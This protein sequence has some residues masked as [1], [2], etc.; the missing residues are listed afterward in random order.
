MKRVEKWFQKQD[1]Y[2]I[3]FFLCVLIAFFTGVFENKMSAGV[4]SVFI[5]PFLIYLL[6]NAVEKKLLNRGADIDTYFITNPKQ[7]DIIW[8]DLAI[9]EMD[10]NSYLVIENTG[11]VDMY[12]FYIKIKNIDGGVF[13]CKIE[14][15]LLTNKKCIVKIPCGCREISEIVI[16]GD[17]LTENK[18]KRFYGKQSSNGEKTIFSSVENCEKEKDSITHEHGI[19]DFVRLERVYEQER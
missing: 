12:E 18:T 16:S 13:L 3:L 15:H 2:E 11:H 4:Y 17:L 19:T 10:Q 9:S 1:T 5:L 7:N 8:K 14:E 6:K